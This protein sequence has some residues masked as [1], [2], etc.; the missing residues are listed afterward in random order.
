[1]PRRTN[2]THR[3]F[4]S[5][6][7]ITLICGAL[8][9]SQAVQTKAQKYSDWSTPVSL[10]PVINST[11]NDQQP[12]ISKNGLSLYFT[13]N[14]PGGLGGFDIY[15]SQRSGVDEPW[16]SPANLGATFNS[17]T[18]EGNPALS[19][20]EHSLFFQSDRPG[21]LGGLDIWVSSR[22]D[23]HDVLAWQTPVNLT[24]VNSSA[25]ENSPSY[26]EN[27]SGLPQLYFASSRA[28]GLGGLDIF[29]S[30]QTSD[31]Y[32]GPA[33][34]IVELSSAGGDSRPS[35]RHNGLEIFLQSDRGGT[36]G[37][38]DL[39]VATRESTL[40]NWSTPLNL[41]TTVNTP[42]LDQNPYLSSDSETLFFASDRPGGV[43]GSDLYLSTRAKLRGKSGQ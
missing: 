8:V 18:N 42:F 20:D 30:E 15:V 33:V 22:I 19:R 4:T 3:T 43:G 17:T 12:A 11:F 28:G 25:G 38:L 39:W 27:E 23:T 29:M 35:I 9:V 34:R 21:G 14:R 10:G 26:F 5:P 7:T 2:K 32:F 16:G 41:G 40:A 13:S 24:A 37:G 6:L 31:G 1:M 36:T